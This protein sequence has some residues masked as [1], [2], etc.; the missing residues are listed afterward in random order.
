MARSSLKKMP[1]FVALLRQAQKMI[2]ERKI[3]LDAETNLHIDHRTRKVRAD[4]LGLT[5]AAKYGDP[6]F[7]CTIYEERVISDRQNPVAFFAAEFDLP[8]TVIATI[9]RHTEIWGQFPPEV[10]AAFLAAVCG[11]GEYDRYI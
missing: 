5:L 6:Y 4:F 8:R 2:T 11:S 10:A 1:R 7:A 3:E 9:D